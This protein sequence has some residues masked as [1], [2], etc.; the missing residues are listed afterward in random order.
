MAMPSYQ[1]RQLSIEVVVY[2][3]ITVGHHAGTVNVRCDDRGSDRCTVTV[4][5]NVSLLVG[6][7]QS[8]Q[9]RAGS[10]LQSSVLAVD[11]NPITEG[12]NEGPAVHKPKRPRSKAWLPH[13]VWAG[14]I[15]IP[16]FASMLA[17]SQTELPEGTCSGIGW[18]CELAG[19]D[20]VGIVVL[21]FGIPLLLILLFGHLIIGLAQ[22]LRSCR[23]NASWGR[24][25][26]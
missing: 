14:V 8:G 12:T 16:F 6:S 23:E 17:L 13:T 7:Q 3:R 22:W 4:E 19:W 11:G 10:Y 26:D 15:V 25:A 20:A 24:I 1:A 21:F 2:S 9:N 5:Y 18:G